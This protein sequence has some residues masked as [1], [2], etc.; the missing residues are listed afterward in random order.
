MTMS[1]QPTPAPRHGGTDAPRRWLAGRSDPAARL[2]A[3]K[4]GLSPKSAE[5]RLRNCFVEAAT[6]IRALHQLGDHVRLCRLMAP[7]DAALAEATPPALTA[8]LFLE[9]QRTDGAEDVAEL[10]LAQ[11]MDPEHKK[12]Y[13]R[14]LDAAIAASQKLRRAVAASLEPA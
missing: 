1:L 7:L 10:D 12:A 11:H 14:R 9:E 5:H 2:A 3:P 6:F 13:L 8:E 4:L